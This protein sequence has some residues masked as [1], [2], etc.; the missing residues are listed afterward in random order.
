MFKKNKHWCKWKQVEPKSVSPCQNVPLPVIHYQKLTT[1]LLP[2]IFAT[3]MWQLIWAINREEKSLRGKQVTKPHAP[4][5][6]CTGSLCCYKPDWLVNNRLRFRLA[7]EWQTYG[8]GGVCSSP[9]DETWQCVYSQHVQ[10]DWVLHHRLD[11]RW[12]PIRANLNTLIVVG[13][14][15]LSSFTQIWVFLPYKAC[16]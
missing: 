11:W 1:V 7:T 3:N 12:M 6:L 4:E 14:Y 16:L 10:P 5:V 15:C 13:C 2:L 9:L 8:G